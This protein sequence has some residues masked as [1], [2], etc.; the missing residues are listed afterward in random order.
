MFNCNVILSLRQPQYLCK[1]ETWCLEYANTT[2]IHESKSVRQQGRKPPWAPYSKLLQQSLTERARRG[3]SGRFSRYVEA[4]RRGE[5]SLQNNNTQWKARQDCIVFAMRSA[6]TILEAHRREPDRLC[7]KATALLDLC[8]RRDG[9]YEGG[10]DPFR[11][12]GGRS[13]RGVHRRASTTDTRVVDSLVWWFR[14]CG[15]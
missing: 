6:Y 10:T 3:L 5:L 12:A 2:A 4:D 14:P 1:S 9:R 13:L 7:F 15:K 11:E 8:V